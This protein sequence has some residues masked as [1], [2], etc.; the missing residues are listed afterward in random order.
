MDDPTLAWRMVKHEVLDGMLTVIVE[1]LND[2]KLDARVLAPV[3]AV[4]RQQVEIVQSGEGWSID[5]FGQALID[6]LGGGF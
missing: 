2:T 5:D 3:T 4:I 6:E 1:V